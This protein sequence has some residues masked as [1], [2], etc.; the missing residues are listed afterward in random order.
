MKLFD[1]NLG[2]YVLQSLIIYSMAMSSKHRK[3]TCA[4]YLE[5]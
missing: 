3:N 2:P 5:I 4:V 1:V